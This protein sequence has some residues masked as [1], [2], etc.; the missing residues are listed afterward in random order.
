MVTEQTIT[1]NTLIDVYKYLN[2]L[3]YLRKIQVESR[4][5]L[6]Q[7]WHFNPYSP[8]GPVQEKAGLE[9]FLSR[10]PWEVLEAGDVQDRPWLVSV[11]S[12]EGL[13]PVSSKCFV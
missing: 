11:T 2:L 3:V 12:E 5:Y 9:P 10:H 8:F 6:L 13:Y 7:P 4:S 1:K